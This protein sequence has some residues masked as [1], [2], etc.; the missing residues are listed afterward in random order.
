MNK[1]TTISLL[2][3]SFFAIAVSVL[4]AEEPT[5]K[6][7]SAHPMQYYLSLPDGWSKSKKWPVVVVI[8]AAEKQYNENASRF[9]D[10]R[11][12]RPFIIVAPLIVT[13]GNQGLHNPEIFPYS[14]ATWKQIDIEGACRF[15]LDGLLHVIDDVQQAYYGEEK[16]YLTGFEAGA[17]LVWAFTF[18]HP[19][20][21]Y[22][23]VS[24][25]GNYI[26][27]CVDETSFSNDPSR[28]KLSLTAFTSES[29][30]NFG[31]HG[32]IHNQ[33]ETALQTAS[34]HG[35]Q[36]VSEKIIKG[37]SH[38]PMPQEVLDYFASLP[39]LSNTSVR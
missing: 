23:S 28:G 26:G 24:V 31:A 18:Q 6:A 35:Y 3:I 36:N 20:K 22:A 37:K 16:V 17:H 13:N 14:E 38:Q 9:A 11:K 39:H 1:S 27:R 5:L 4:S 8:E 33:T 25:D 15:D 12:G 29:D 7:V 30:S 19:E 2:V 34:Q 32:R 21:L 10:A